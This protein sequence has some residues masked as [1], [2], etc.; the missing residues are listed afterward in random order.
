MSF[1]DVVG[2][3]RQII[4]LK[5][6]ISSKKIPHAYLFSG[7]D[8]IGKKKTA[9]EMIKYLN[10]EN[11]DSK[12]ILS[13]ETCPACIRMK[14]SNQPDY[15]LI[16]D[17]EG[18][19]KI[20]QVRNLTAV[21][22]LKNTISK[23]KCVIINNC[24]SMT[25]EGANSLLKIIEEPG[26]NVIFFLITS[27]EHKVLPTIKS[28]AQKI[29]FQ[30]LSPA[31]LKILA[32][33]M[34]LFSDNLEFLIDYSQGSFGQ[35]K[36]LIQNKDFLEELNEFKNIFLEIKEKPLFQVMHQGKIFEKDKKKLL[37]FL[38]YY[39]YRL[40]QERSSYPSGTVK[41]VI[42]EIIKAQEMLLRNINPRF[43]GEMILI[44]SKSILKG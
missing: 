9:E 23:Y 30:Q 2:H 8:G 3:E 40:E 38:D 10:C 15:F 14:N 27:N 36:N 20:D 18:T 42:D 32:E 35:L 37:R 21:L 44:K 43:V 41:A 34:S 1:K 13:C 29:N 26:E 17:T 7:P 6:T 11:Q 31:E 5:K 22:S 25:N 12:E 33:R 28:R 4:Q 39:V 19:I 24:E 16:T